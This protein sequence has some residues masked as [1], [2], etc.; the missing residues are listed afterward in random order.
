ML[1]TRVK[2]KS[3]VNISSGVEEWK[4]WGLIYWKIYSSI[5]IHS[6]DLINKTNWNVCIKVDQNSFCLICGYEFTVGDNYR[7]IIRVEEPV[8]Q[9]VLL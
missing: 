9:R 4:M 1:R 7:W 8:S 6:S 3:W 5:S 2:Y